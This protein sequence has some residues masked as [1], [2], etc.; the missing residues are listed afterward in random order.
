MSVSSALYQDNFGS[1]LSNCVWN[2]LSKGFDVG[3]VACGGRKR[4]VEFQ[5]LSVSLASLVRITSP[6]EEIVSRFM[7]IDVYY[8]RVV[9]VSVHD[10]VAVVCVDVQVD[11]ALDVVF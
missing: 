2:N 7:E 11:Q 10:T 1:E 4:Y 5:A 3:L 6:R 9:V 8:N